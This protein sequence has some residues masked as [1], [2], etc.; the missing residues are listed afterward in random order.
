MTATEQ[1]T[2]EGPRRKRRPGKRAGLDVD[3]IIAAAR[4]LPLE[5]LSMQS[6]ADVLKVDR[7]ALH[8]HVKDRQSLFELLARDT[9]SRRLL[10]TEVS[11][12]SDWKEACR[13]YASE[14][15][16]AAV[17]LAELVDYLWF[18]DLM[19]DLPLKPVESMFKQL[20]EAG[21][22]DEEAVR[23]M[24]VLGTLCLGHA[25]DLAQA[26][27]EAARTRSHLLRSVLAKQKGHDYPHLERI[28]SLNVD[29]YNAAQIDFSIE[30][31]LDGVE[32]RLHD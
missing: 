9:F 16:D 26:H 23:L 21:F 8:Y 20:S 27:K 15:A 11:D 1:G 31:I 3:Q 12:A 17:G 10:Q 22:T 19:N 5:T 7:K 14:L 6:L 32:R 28:S 2:Q 4:T 18:S 30:L 25:R 13:I 24:T 29:T